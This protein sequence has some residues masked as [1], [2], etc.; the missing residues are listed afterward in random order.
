MPSIMTHPFASGNSQ[1]VRLP[2]SIAFPPNTPLIITKENDVVTITPV[3]TMAHVP[4]LFTAL[5]KHLPSDFELDEL[6]EN[7]R[8]W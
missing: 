4:A 5:G 8:A 6:E 7:E 3:K 1:A 2:K